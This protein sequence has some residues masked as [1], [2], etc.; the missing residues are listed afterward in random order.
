MQQTEIIMGMP[1]T[2]EIVDEGATADDLNEVFDYFRKV[3]ARYST[4]KKDSEI[5]R[6]NDGLP[7]SKWSSEMKKVL[8]LCE[9]TRQE[10]DGFFDIT[11]EGYT[12]PSGLVKGWSIQNAAKLLKLKGFHNFYIDGGGDIQ[13]SGH[14]TEGKNWRIGIRNP[15]DRTQTIKALT[16][17]NK[18][19]ATSGTY[20]RGTH[21]YNPHQNYKPASEVVALTVIGPDIYNADRFATAAFAMGKNGINIIEKLKGFEGYM[22]DHNAVATLTSNFERYVAA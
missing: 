19:V 6:I 17:K 1:I 2:I 13:V 5:S 10:T 9:Q 11:R 14:S 4:Y 8:Q 22:I 3:D 20:I 12:D 7:K 16:V 21:V 18:G 15:F